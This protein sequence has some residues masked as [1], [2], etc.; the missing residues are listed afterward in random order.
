MSRE[1]EF[2]AGTKEYGRNKE[3]ANSWSRGIFSR[4]DPRSLLNRVNLIHSKIVKTLR[5]PAG[6]GD[7]YAIDLGVASQ[8]EMQP[9][10]VLRKV[11]G[12]PRELH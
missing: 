12:P 9:E 3:N 5:Q 7:F 11:T 10:I 2:W 4:A 8:P 1:E 6:P